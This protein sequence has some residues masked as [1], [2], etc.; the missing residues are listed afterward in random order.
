MSYSSRLTLHACPRKYQLYRLNTVVPVDET[1]PEEIKQSVTFAFGHCVGLGIQE[2]LIHG[3]LT[4]AIWACFI[5]WDCDLLESN[6]VQKKSFALAI[7]AIQKFHALCANGYLDDWELAYI[8]GK[9]AVELSFIIE[10]PDG[11]TYK[12]FLD[13]A[14]RNRSTGRLMVLECK[15]TSATSVNAAMYK[16]SAQAVGYSVILDAIDPEA[17]AYDV[18]YL[19]YKTKAT[20]FEQMEFQK[21]YLTRALWIREMLL[22]VEMMKL[23]EDTSIYPMHGESCFSFYR[24]CKYLGI[25]ELPT[26]KLITALEPDQE[27]KILKGNSADFHVNVTLADLVNTQLKRST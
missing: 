5:M 19:V 1:D 16:N 17:S 26:D 7:H 9:P 23:Y 12:G 27:E 18:R 24:E 4:K 2:L 15:T 22:D 8:N 20:D 21:S 11:F 10:F 3:D 13:A 6:P 14:V 25:C